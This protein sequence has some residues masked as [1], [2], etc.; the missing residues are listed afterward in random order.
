MG[1]MFLERNSNERKSFGLVVASERC[2]DSTRRFFGI[3]VWKFGV[4][5]DFLIDTEAKEGDFCDTFGS[6]NVKADVDGGGRLLEVAW[7][8]CCNFVSAVRVGEDS[9]REM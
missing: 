7:A 5:S 9:T 8:C 1:E 6:R 4:E 2:G 3:I